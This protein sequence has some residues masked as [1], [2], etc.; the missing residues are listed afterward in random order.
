M[1]LQRVQNSGNMSN[2][3]TT[4]AYQFT[5]VAAQ[6]ASCAHN[7]LEL[8]N[9]TN[10]TPTL[11]CQCGSRWELTTLRYALPPVVSTEY[12]GGC[13]QPVHSSQPTCTLHGM[14]AA[15]LTCVLHGD[16]RPMVMCALEY[17]AHALLEM[18]FVGK[19]FATEVLKTAARAVLAKI[20]ALEGN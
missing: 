9:S 12:C 20:K 6:R 1:W 16:D 19:E 3:T 8:Y 5:R 18:D 13:Q 11:A 15:A 7:L 17:T 4:G 14:R 2:Y 10:G